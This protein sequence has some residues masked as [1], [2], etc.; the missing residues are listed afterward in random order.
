[1][2]LLTF[3]ATGT[4]K[5]KAVEA[6]LPEVAERLLL[7]GKPVGLET[8]EAYKGACYDLLDEDKKQ[9]RLAWSRGGAPPPPPPRKPLGAISSIGKE[10][11]AIAIAGRTTKYNPGLHKREGKRPRSEPSTASF[12]PPTSRAEMPSTQH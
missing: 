12:P 7:S 5:S 2:I 1:M 9:P 8:A 11:T 6:L 4:R 10:P 3:G